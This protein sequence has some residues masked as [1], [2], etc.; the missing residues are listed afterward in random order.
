LVGYS[1]FGFPINKEAC[2]YLSKNGVKGRARNGES[3]SKRR[4]DF[5]ELR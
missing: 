1:Y 4:K 3:A 5:E 2:I